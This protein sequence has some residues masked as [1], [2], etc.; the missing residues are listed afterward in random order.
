TWDSMTAARR[1]S[2][3]SW[4]LSVAMSAGG[5]FTL[6]ASLSVVCTRRCSWRVASLWAWATSIAISVSSL[7]SAATSLTRR[8]ARSPASPDAAGA[9]D[10]GAAEGSLWDEG[11]VADQSSG[12][13]IQPWRIAY[14]TAWVRSL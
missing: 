10:D 3:T 6:V 14:T 4:A 12:I 13:R 7:S 8:V 11:T 2:D 9:V 1:V 5:K